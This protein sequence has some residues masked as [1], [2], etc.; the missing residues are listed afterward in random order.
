[1]SDILMI[2]KGKE[3]IKKAKAFI[4]SLDEGQTY[5]VLTCE[6]GQK[7]EYAEHGIDVHYFGDYSIRQAVHAKYDKDLLKIIT[8]QLPGCR[9][10]GITF[11]ELFTF[12]NISLWDVIWRIIYSVLRGGCLKYAI[13][14]KEIIDAERPKKVIIVSPRLWFSK[15]LESLARQHNIR[16]VYASGP[17]IYEGSRKIAKAIVR[18]L[19][20]GAVL[21][22]KIIN[23]ELLRLSKKDKQGS[24]PRKKILFLRS[25]INRLKSILPVMRIMVRSGENK[26][27]LMSSGASGVGKNEIEESLQSVSADDHLSFRMIREIRKVDTKCRISWKRIKDNGSVLE[28]ITYQGI[29]IWEFLEPVVEHL[30]FNAFNPISK[31]VV[32]AQSIVKKEKPDVFVYADE[33]NIFSKYLTLFARNNKIPV[34]RVQYALLDITDFAKLECDAFAVS[35]VISKELVLQYNPASEERVVITGQPRYD[36]ITTRNADRSEFCKKQGLDPDKKILLFASTYYSNIS[37]YDNVDPWSFQRYYYKLCDIYSAL[38]KLSGVELIVKP[39]PS[40]KDPIE[41]HRA[42]L[43]EIKATSRFKFFSPSGSIVDLLRNCDLCVTF[44]STTAIEAIALEKPMVIID[45][46]NTLNY[47]SQLKEEIAVRVF[48]GDDIYSAVKDTLDNEEL[49]KKMKDNQMRIK[50]RFIYKSDGKAAERIAELIDSVMR[51]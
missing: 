31:Y 13:I 51:G 50:E 49:Q 22:S 46:K 20:R 34:V 16:I 38:D 15:I 21:R 7:E 36:V 44:G 33:G 40:P 3:D 30:F 12:G 25:T 42:V 5:K 6:W 32:L 2:I 10:D 24:A 41:M 47:Y 18:P 28:N 37:F 19:L 9:F 4:K 35:N 43:K 11:R 45:I 17:N 14:I 27:I 23:A 8:E 29:S 1:M 26:V 39:H 48:D